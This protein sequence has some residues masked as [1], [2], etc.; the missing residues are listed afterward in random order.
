MMPTV[1]PS[2]CRNE[3]K[4]CPFCGGPADLRSYTNAAGKKSWTVRCR[5]MCV[6][7]CSR[8]D[9]RGRW[10]PTLRKEAIEIWNRRE[11]SENAG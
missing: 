11:G 4:P 2:S 9:E 6:V 5:N 3:L 7:T 8:R 1:S 10:R